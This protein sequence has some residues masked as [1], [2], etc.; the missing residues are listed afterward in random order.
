V[1]VTGLTFAACGSDS[2]DVPS[3]NSVEGSSPADPVAD[4]V[5][6]DEAKMMAFTQCL[7]DQGIEVLDPVVDSEGNV[8]KPQF[9][10]GIDAK[11]KEAWDVCA[12]HLEGMTFGR[13]GVDVVDQ[14]DRLDQFLALATCL[15]DKGYDVA[16]PT[17]E[18][19]DQWMGDF[20]D[21][22]N[23]DDPDSIADYE[24]CSGTQIGGK[25]GGKK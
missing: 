20:K 11:G 6:D 17:A 15:R 14:I 25:S 16:D 5:L 10:E 9:V 21:A 19:L 8:G 4:A 23:W 7:R 2:D 24:E 1:A 22:V 18:T 3:L 12:E 13:K